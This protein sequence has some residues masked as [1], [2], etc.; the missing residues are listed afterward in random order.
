MMPAR[1]WSGVPTALSRGARAPLPELKPVKKS[2]SLLAA[3]L[4]LFV[5]NDTLA[6]QALVSDPEIYEKKFFQDK[7]KVVQFDSGFVKRQDINNDGLVDA[8]VSHG[9]VVCDGERGVGCNS[10]GCL[11]NLYLQ[12]KEGGYLMIATARLYSLDY[13]VRYG[14]NLIAMKMH[15]RFCDRAEGEEPCLIVSRIRGTTLYTVQK[16]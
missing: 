6:Q 3:A 12:V 2:R 13:E 1:R 16:K 7:C 11:Y 15:P 4:L 5:A 10:D 8:V 14:N 9:S